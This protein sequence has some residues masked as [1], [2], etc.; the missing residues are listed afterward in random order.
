M[1]SLL[2]PPTSTARRRKRKS[3][4][5]L[6]RQV[7]A[8]QPLCEQCRRE[9][10]A[11][12]A[13]EV[14]HVLRSSTHPELLHDRDNLQALCRRCHEAKTARENSRSRRIRPPTVDGDLAA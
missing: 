2:A 13:V 9:G 8:E 7:L 1:L 10:R 11:A 5:A 3:Y 12:A 6:R 14:D 4:Q